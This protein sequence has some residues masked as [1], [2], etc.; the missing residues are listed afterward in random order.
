MKE[1]VVG[2]A[3]IAMTAIIAFL[4]ILLFPIL[5]LMGFF[6]RIFVG[7]ALILFVVWL[8]GKVTLVLI[9]YVRKQEGRN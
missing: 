6:L 2:L 7:L 4:G 5:L 8:I 9:E 3:V 1:F